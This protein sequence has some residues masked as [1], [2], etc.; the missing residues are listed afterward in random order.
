MASMDLITVIGAATFGGGILF[1]IILVVVAAGIRAEGQLAWRRGTVTLWDDPASR[2]A[3]G[4]RRVNGV[5]L[6]TGELEAVPTGAARAE[7]VTE[8]TSERQ[9]KGLSSAA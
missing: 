6:R 1:G 3:Q 4:V 9:N 8:R 2:L 5:G 7:Q